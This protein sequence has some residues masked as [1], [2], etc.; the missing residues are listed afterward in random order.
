[1]CVLGA[2]S[3]MSLGRRV[4]MMVNSVDVQQGSRGEAEAGEMTWETL[5]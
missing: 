2:V 4:N 1:M 5:N 3:V